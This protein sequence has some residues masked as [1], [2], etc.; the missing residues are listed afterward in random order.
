M[1]RKVDFYGCRGLIRNHNTVVITGNGIVFYW[2]K[3]VNLCISMMQEK[4][5]HFA[6][7]EFG[8]FRIYKAQF[9]RMKL[10]CIS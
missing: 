6:N 5:Q 10:Q 9:G 3:I 2:V 1:V 8:P 7:R 4:R